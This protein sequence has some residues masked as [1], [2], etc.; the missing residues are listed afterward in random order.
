V[1]FTEQVHTRVRGLNAEQMHFSWNSVLPRLVITSDTTDFD[2][3]TI[4]N[5]QEEGFQISYL[6]YDGDR[7][8]YSN[9]LRHLADSLELGDK[10]AIVGK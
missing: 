8:E 9:Q 7:K 4:N 5:F 10:Y 3:I 6:H 2:R 1:T